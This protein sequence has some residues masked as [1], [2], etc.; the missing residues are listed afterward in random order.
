MSDRVVVFRYYDFYPSG[1]FGDAWRD[2]SGD[3]LVFDSFEEAQE[4]VK[5][6]GS[7]YENANYVSLETLREL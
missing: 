5:R 1:G 3:V 6:D 2:E 7:D 4:A